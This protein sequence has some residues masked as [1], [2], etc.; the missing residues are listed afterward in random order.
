MADPPAPSQVSEYVAFVVS[1]P[2]DWDPL[3]ALGPLHAPDAVQ[4]VASVA[5]Q[6]IVELPPLVIEVGD[7]LRV[8]VGTGGGE[9]T[10][11]VAD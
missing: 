10:A 6:V 9:F 2:V 1:V 11:T 8:N 7:A 3:V 5:D 4:L